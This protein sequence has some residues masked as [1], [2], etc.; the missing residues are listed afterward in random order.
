MGAFFV[1]LRSWNKTASCKRDNEDIPWLV[2][3]FTLAL[4]FFLQLDISRRIDYNGQQQICCLS[5]FS[6]FRTNLMRRIQK[7]HWFCSIRSS[8]FSYGHMSF[9]TF[10]FTCTHVW[11][12]LEDVSGGKILR[13]IIVLIG[14]DYFND[15]KYSGPIVLGDYVEKG[16]VGSHKTSKSSKNWCAKA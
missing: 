15:K 7:S 12:I 8:F 1:H 14:N 10:L 11:R 6:W 5:F 9:F 3:N 2:A 13:W 4:D 16:W